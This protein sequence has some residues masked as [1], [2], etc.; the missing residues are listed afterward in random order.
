M[1]KKRIIGSLIIAV[2]FIV[3][4]IVGYNIQK[5]STDSENSDM[6]VPDNG[7]YTKKITES[8]KSS[9]K[10]DENSNNESS[11]SG[12]QNAKEIKAQIYGEVKNPGVYSLSNGSRIKDLIDKAG[13]YT[14]DANC[15]SING[16]KKLIDGDNIDVKSKTDK[17]NITNVNSDSED[18]SSS[19][20]EKI[21]INSATEDDI[22]NKK[23]PGIGKGL[24]SKI[25]KYREQN[26]GR[27]NSKSDIEKAI[28]TKRAQKI[29]DYIQI[30]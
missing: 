2:T 3:F 27:I 10:N 8:S 16:A 12:N 4:L 5:S 26:G 9:N 20:V 19:E 25:I 6:T 7:N 14:D 11:N 15:F 18:S 22:V 23:I 29:M 28:G 21:D 13:G 30:D 1:N 24:A 17:S